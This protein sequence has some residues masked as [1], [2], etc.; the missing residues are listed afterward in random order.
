MRLASDRTSS[1]PATPDPS[2][3]TVVPR[4]PVPNVVELTL[5]RRKDPRCE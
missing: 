5:S 3:V 1:T 4:V 2:G